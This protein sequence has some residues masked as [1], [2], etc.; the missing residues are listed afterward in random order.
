MKLS[1]LEFACYIYSRMTDYDSSYE[2]F[3]K[4]TQPE[5]NFRLS[6]QVEALLH[7]LNKWGCRQFAKKYHKEAAQELVKW[8]D[9]VGYLIFA[10]D[11]S[12]LELTEQDFHVVE[13]LYALLVH[14]IASF[15]KGGNVS[16]I[17]VEVGPTG[18]SK[19]LFAWR[20]QAF[21]PW[22]ESMRA[23]A[24]LDGSAP[25]Y[26][27]YLRRVQD[28]LLELSHECRNVG[29]EITDLPTVLRRPHSS[30]TK[31]MDEYSWVTITRKC[32]VPEREVLLRWAS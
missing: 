11:K 27:V 18:A 8:H 9:E 30:L 22:D 17:K 20:P 25:S 32:T 4:A 24:K 29:F 16:R 31:L 23:K 26:L 2:R 7:W 21:I 28:Q 5:L 1:D 6:E 14:K 12:I 10:S 13:Q 19:I 15:R 3:L